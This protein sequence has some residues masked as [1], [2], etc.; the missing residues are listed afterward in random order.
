M[1][2][3]IE[4]KS[5]EVQP[6]PEVQFKSPVSDVKPKKQKRPALDV[7]RKDRNDPL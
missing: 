6:Q 5:E 2:T 1:S 4:M 7:N 3:T